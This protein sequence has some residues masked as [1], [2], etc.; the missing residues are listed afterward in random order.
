MA[1][2]SSIL[3]RRIPWT[4][5]PGVLQSMGLQKSQTQLNNNNSMVLQESC[6]QLEVTVLYLGG[7][8]SSCRRTQRGVITH[9]PRRNQY[10]AAQ[11][12]HAFPPSPK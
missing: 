11:L 2:H 1:T 10:P 6:A 4:E 3:A 12:F 7:G 9:I 8:L 5:E